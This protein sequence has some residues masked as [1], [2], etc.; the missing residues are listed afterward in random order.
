VP[1]DTGPMPGAEPFSS[2]GFGDRARV[3]ALL[4]HGFTGS[5]ASMRPWGQHLADAGLAVRV[6]LLPGHG[7]RWQDLNETRWTDWYDAAEAAFEDLRS[8]CD[9]VFV[10]G[11]SMGGAVAVRLAEEHGDD[12]AGV[13]LVN[14][15]LSTDDRRAALLP[16]VSQVVSSMPPVGGDIKRPGVSEGA[17]DR[18][19]TKAAASLRT[20]WGVALGDLHRI[21]A[22]VLVFRSTEDHVVPASSVN[23]LVAGAANTTVEVRALVNSYHVATLDND[24][25]RIFA[26]SLVFMTSPVAAA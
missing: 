5:P 21:T 4:I 12:L 25:P 11:L 26:E 8:R 22:P 7:T 10:G 17:Y 18:M 20:L 6:P 15:S 23:K 2:D 1:T 14:P 9:Q 24:A 13:V 3:G 19:P 16:L